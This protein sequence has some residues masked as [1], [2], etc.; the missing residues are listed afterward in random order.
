MSNGLKIPP[1]ALIILDFLT[2]PQ[3]LVTMNKI[4]LFSVFCSSMSYDIWLLSDII[5]ILS[6]V[7]NSLLFVKYFNIIL[8]YSLSSLI[9]L[10]H[11]SYFYIILPYSPTFH[12]ILH[13]STKSDNILPYLLSFDNISYL[14]TTF[15]KILHHSPSSL[16]LR[17]HSTNRHHFSTIFFDI[18][19]FR[20]HLTTFYKIFIRQKFL[21]FAVK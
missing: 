18:I 13:H 14:S 10:Q 15:S 1:K 2:Y 11:I 16:I 3:P 12:I 5:C 19:F 21:S 17:H 9:I 4:G 20:Q 6:N 7:V 8:P